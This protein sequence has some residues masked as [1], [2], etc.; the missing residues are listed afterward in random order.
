[1]LAV[2]IILSNLTVPLVG[3]V[4]TAVM[5]RMPEPVYLSATAVGAV[6]FSTI[7]WAFG[8]LRMGT[9]GLVAQA[10]GAQNPDEIRQTTWRSLLLGAALG[11]AIIA[12]SA[13]L[14][15]L[16]MQVMGG[17]DALHSL[18]RDYYYTRII[19]AP[20]TL[21]LYGVF[22]SLIGQQRMKSVFSLQLLL[23]GLNIVLNI[24]FF[25]TTDWAIRGVA[26][27][28]V[29]SE[30]VTLLV[31]LWVLYPVLS[32][33]VS[34]HRSGVL[35]ACRGLF[36]PEK[37]RQ[38]FRIGGDIFIRSL[39]LT[40]AFYWL[41]AKG[42]RQGELILAANGIFLQMVHFMAYGLDGF[43]HA[44]ETLTGQALGRRDHRSLKNAVHASTWWAVMLALIITV[45]YYLAGDVI[46]DGMTT[47]A[48][49]RLTAREYW[50][51]VAAAPLIGVW[52]FLLDGI[53]IG[54]TH[55]REMRNGMLIS[56]VVFVVSAQLLVPALGNHGL[57]LAYY[58][59]MVARA[60]TLAMWYPRILRAASA[61][62]T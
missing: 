40:A 13:P 36:S 21:M 17:S 30:Y 22:G 41:T 12:L 47:Q 59:L 44:A 25:T 14:L 33:R 55:T 7:Y 8:F 10:L 35:H 53:F 29:I 23:N 4:D 1:M 19:S 46:I 56:F 61:V 39:C 50:P 2:P 28:T 62:H 20:A 48:E 54:T 31:G 43:S 34:H 57:W 27:A 24:L 32:S 9:G 37:L 5:G 6:L 15:W 38:F 58:A 42:A 18:T 16:G 11:F 26:A 49:V 3:I 52:S 51:W 45:I 60:V